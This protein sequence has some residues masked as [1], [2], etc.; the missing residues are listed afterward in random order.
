MMSATTNTPIQEISYDEER[1][2]NK[3]RKIKQIEYI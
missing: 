1:I 3:F 2:N